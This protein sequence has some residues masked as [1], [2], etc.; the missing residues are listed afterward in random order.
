M[1]IQIDSEWPLRITISNFLYHWFSNKLED[2]CL[3]LFWVL[4]GGRYLRLRGKILMI[5]II[6]FP[7]FFFFCGALYLFAWSFFDF[8]ILI[9]NRILI[10]QSLSFS[11][12]LHLLIWC[13]TFL[14]EIYILV[15]YSFTDTKNFK[16]CWKLLTHY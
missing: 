3:V 13:D 6:L 14:K 4:L 8:I 2:F 15:W 10:P 7:F 16:T 11:L 9:L 5:L 1:T 12:W